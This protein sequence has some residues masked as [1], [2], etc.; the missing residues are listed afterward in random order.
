MNKIIYAKTFR[1]E[2]IIKIAVQNNS[3]TLLSFEIDLLDH[4]KGLPVPIPIKRKNGV[5]LKK[6]N[7]HFAF[8][9]T[10]LPGKHRLHANDIMLKEVGTFLAKMH[11][12]TFRY[13]ST[14]RRLQTLSSTT[15][16]LKNIFKKCDSITDKKINNTYVYIK[17]NILN[18]LPPKDVPSGAIH[19]DLKPENCLFNKDKL[20]GVVDFDN[21]Y[22]GPL[23]VDLANTTIWFC[24]RGNE[25][26]ISKSNR[27]LKSYEKI[28]KLT[29]KENNY[30]SNALHFVYLRNLLRGVEYWKRGKVSKKF[31]LWAI[32]YFLKPEKL[33]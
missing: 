32:D 13:K 12:K 6:I 15:V 28:R 5:S 8:V 27:I 4:L 19:S 20:T 1:G 26:D 18:Y 30:Y 7:N 9:M 33:N 10:F 2:Y 23:I 31:M 16:S 25:L 21:S 24:R 11:K 3:K 14:V 17:N 29:T 22:F